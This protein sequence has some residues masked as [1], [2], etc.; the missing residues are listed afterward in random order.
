MFS[1]RKSDANYFESKSRMSVTFQF[2][3]YSSDDAMFSREDSGLLSHTK[4]RC[5]F[6][7]NFW[8]PKD[9]ILK[10]QKKGVGNCTSDQEVGK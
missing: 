2:G 9:I 8:I 5:I 10:G 4:K 1:F 3:R 7:T 6:T